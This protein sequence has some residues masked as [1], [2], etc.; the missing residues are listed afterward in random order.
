MLLTKWHNAVAY[1]KIWFFCDASLGSANKRRSEE[2]RRE[3]E[4]DEETRTQSITAGT[5][6]GG[7]DEKLL[8]REAM[9]FS[10]DLAAGIAGEEGFAIDKGFWVGGGEKW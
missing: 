8:I 3:G 6:A 5:A 9:G 4:R 10:G 1:D 7:T 2:K